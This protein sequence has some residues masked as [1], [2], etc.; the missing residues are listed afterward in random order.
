VAQFMPGTAAERGLGDPYDPALAIDQAARFLAELAARFG[1]LG[2]AAAA[3][4]AGPQRVVKWL[5]RSSELPTETQLYI[6]AITGRQAEEWRAGPAGERAFIERG[7]CLE[8]TADL[9][10]IGV[11]RRWTDS[12]PARM[13]LWQVRLDKFLE[14]A[15]RLQQQR[16]GTV[17]VSNS[18][19][20]AASFCDRIRAMGL[21]CAVYER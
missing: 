18:N 7:N 15:V 12:A 4:N 2:L 9:G 10:H 16:P 6:L 3:Y 17:P 11:P 1:S 21:P 19:R 14:K 20:A 5:Q 8:V 13:A